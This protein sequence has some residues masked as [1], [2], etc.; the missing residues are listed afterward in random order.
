VI[1][2]Y[3]IEVGEMDRH[4]VAGYNF[5]FNELRTQCVRNSLKWGHKRHF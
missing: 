3:Q 2:V 1:T 4:L 5:G